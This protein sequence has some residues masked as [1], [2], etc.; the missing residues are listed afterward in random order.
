LTVSLTDDTFASPIFTNK[1]L[2]PGAFNITTVSH[3]L[4]VTTTNIAT[5]TGVDQNGTSVNAQAT[6]TVQ[7]IH[8]AISLTKTPSATKVENG[9]SVT[10]TYNVTN[11]GDTSLTVSLTDDTFASPIFTNK[12]LA[13]GA[14]NITTVSH[15]LTANTTNIA[16]ATGVDQNGTSV[17]ANAN[18]FVQVIHPAI[19]LTKTADPSTPQLAP[20]NFT[21]TYVVTNIG[22]VS[23]SNVRV[24]DETFNQLILGPVTLSVGQSA[25]GTY[26]PVA[27][28]NVTASY[29]N[30]ANTTGVDQNG[31]SVEAFA[32]A[33]VSLYV[34]PPTGGFL[35]PVNTLMFLFAT[36]EDIL[37]S[38]YGVAAVL[39]VGAIAAL[40]IFK[41]RRK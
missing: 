22:D 18:A 21:Y 11:T 40:A 25:Q 17:N 4:T 35:Q 7:V 14:F 41:R 38:N 16:T 37:V 32:E 33:T 24:Y 6:A 27:Y 34:R 1:V 12:V 19:S 13:P 9:S 26:G 10:Y 2:A 23:L 15:V 3:V 29:T 30:Y 31:T 8:P 39:A 20:A 36:I 5:A 28:P